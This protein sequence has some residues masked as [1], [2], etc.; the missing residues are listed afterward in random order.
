ML[1]SRFVQQ[2]ALG[3][4][5]NGTVIGAVDTVRGCELVAVKIISRSTCKQAKVEYPSLE[6]NLA[7]R[8]EHRNIARFLEVIEE[9]DCF[10]LVQEQLRGGDLFTSMQS[11]DDVFPEF[12]ARCLFRDLLCGVQYLHEQLIAHR[13]LK[14]ENCVLDSEGTLK[15]V[16]FG[17][18]VCFTTGELFDDF[19][20]SLDYAPPEVLAQTPYEA[21]LIDMWAMGVILFDMVMGDLPFAKDEQCFDLPLQDDEDGVAPELVSLLRCLLC[22][23]AKNRATVQTV[24]QSEWLNLGVRA[25][26]GSGVQLISRRPSLCSSVSA[27]SSTSSTSK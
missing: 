27:S 21:P 14:P 24:A 16:D 22:K 25:R 6:V 11:L 26:K 15:L 17:A 5:C 1:G 20:G 9:G 7:R 10:L 12:L 23:D 3:S 2:F 13:D 4:G 19:N 8:L 18:A